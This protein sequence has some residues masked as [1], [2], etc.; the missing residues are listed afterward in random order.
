MP[1]DPRHPAA[2]LR[3]RCAASSSGVGSQEEQWIEACGSV[4][5]PRKNMN[6]ARRFYKGVKRIKG[7]IRSA[8]SQKS[9]FYD[10]TLNTHR[11]EPGTAHELD[12]GAVWCATSQTHVLNATCRIL[13]VSCW[14][15]IITVR[16]Q[17]SRISKG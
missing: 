6:M 2:A 3:R 7:V 5:N 9:V 1:H 4:K 13:V 15:Y 17:I 16:F 8:Y 14:P 11:F 12:L 10:A